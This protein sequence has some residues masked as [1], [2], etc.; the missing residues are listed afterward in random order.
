MSAGDTRNRIDEAKLRDLFNPE[1]VTR[2]IK[3]VGP[4]LAG[5]RNPVL[6][7]MPLAW[8]I[9]HI[10]M[11]P[12]AIWELYGG[13]KDRMVLLFP[14]SSVAPHSR[15]VRAVIEPHFKI[16]ETDEPGIMIMGHVDAGILSQGG[17]TWYQRGP[18][19]V[20][21]DYIKLLS[22]TGRQPRHMALPPSV[23]NEVDTFLARLGVGDTDK[24]VV[25]N[26]RDR[27]YMADQEV[28]FYRT[29]D[30][31][32]YETALLHLLDRGYWVLRLGVDGTVPASIKAPRYVEV[33]KEPDYSDLLDPGLIARA[34]FGITCSSG[35]EAVFRILGTPQL[36][37]NGVLQCSMWM[38]PRDRLL[39]KSYRTNEGVPASLPAM[40]EKGVAIRSDSA[41]VGQCGFTAQDN[42][43][44]EI[45]AAVR[46]MEEALGSQPAEADDLDRRFLE[47]GC[48][49]Q[50]FLTEIGHPRDPASL[51]ARPTQFG[52]AL[53]WTR[54]SA[55]N[56]SANPNFLE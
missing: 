53:P 5:S 52:Y 45:L 47:I 20:L 27:N 2:L 13:E 28:H 11:E 9:G 24:V 18:A 22:H 50:S 33:W 48:A 23:R 21:D 19:G 55:A 30:I 25:L 34:H 1:R 26:V 29:A 43:P 8:R 51:S 12:H 3:I 14:L 7:I 32:S 35:P 44:A 39:F 49:Y 38:N 16:V 4:H 15:G 46:D 42:T 56:Q 6:H 40:L 36:M 10:A 41:S 17:F 31:A 54:L 37:V